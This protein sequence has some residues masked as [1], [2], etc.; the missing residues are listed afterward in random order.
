VRA[1]KLKAK[2]SLLKR[3]LALNIWLPKAQLTKLEK[4]QNDPGNSTELPG[5]LPFF[6][7]AKEQ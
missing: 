5:F 4:P 7:K 1:Q 3:E 2:R 6:G